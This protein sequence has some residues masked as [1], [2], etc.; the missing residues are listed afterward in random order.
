MTASLR[1]AGVLLAW[2]PVAGCTTLST[3]LATSSSEAAC[4]AVFAQAADSGDP[5]FRLGNALAETGD[6]EGAEQAYRQSLRLRPDA[7]TQHNLALVRLQL[8]LGDLQTA[9]R[10]LPADDP[11]RVASRAYLHELR[12]TL[13]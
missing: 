12:Q 13:P 3:G 6:Y 2:L 9:A 1:M 4:R 10:V 7:R 11:A 8:G 5:W